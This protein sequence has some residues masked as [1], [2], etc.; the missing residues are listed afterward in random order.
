MNFGRGSASVFKTEYE[1]KAPPMGD[2]DGASLETSPILM[3]SCGV[4]QNGGTHDLT[5]GLSAEEINSENSRFSPSN[6][7]EYC[8]SESV[9]YY[10][11]LAKN[12]YMSNDGFHSSL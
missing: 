9:A 11:R 4:Q 7:V 2:P 3:M 1:F 12:S 10:K 6:I 8:Q 5:S